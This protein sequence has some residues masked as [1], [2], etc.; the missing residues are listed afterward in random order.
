MFPMVKTHLPLYWFA[1]WQIK[2]EKFFS[3]GFFAGLTRGIVLPSTNSAMCL[4]NPE[5]ETS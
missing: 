4:I 1:P 3:R 5:E 2:P